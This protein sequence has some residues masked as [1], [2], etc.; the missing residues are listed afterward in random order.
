MPYCTHHSNTGVHVHALVFYHITLLNELLTAHITAIWALTTMQMFM[1]YEVTL[2]TKC[3]TAHIT[4]L[5]GFTS[6]YALVFYHITLLN[7][8]LTAHITAIWALT[9]MWTFRP[10][11]ITLT[12][13]N[14]TANIT[15]ISM[16]TSLCIKMLILST[17]TL[18]Y[19]LTERT[20]IL[21]AVCE[22][23]KKL[24]V[25]KSCIFE[26][27]HSISTHH[28]ILN[29]STD[30]SEWQYCMYGLLLGS[31]NI[32]NILQKSQNHRC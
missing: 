13:E 23:T 31:M 11:K 28:K 12:I 22:L 9:T 4:A 5:R 6:M 25:L 17:P 7:K 3:L 29:V 16:L 30:S 2:S 26:A 19:F 14:L 21:H 32:H 20:S 8:L 1:W 18:G 15:W 27:K 10:H 24:L